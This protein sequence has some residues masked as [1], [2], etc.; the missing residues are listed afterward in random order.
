MPAGNDLWGRAL[1]DYHRGKKKEPLILHTSFGEP[2]EVPL[3]VFF[4]QPHEFS[5][6]EQFAMDLCQGPVLDVGAGTGC[7]SLYL[8]R[9]KL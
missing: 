5:D 6:L 4:R 7:H 9:E 3:G 2:E 8:Q 1:L